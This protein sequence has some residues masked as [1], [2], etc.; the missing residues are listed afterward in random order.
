MFIFLMHL[1]ESLR[2]KALRAPCK[3][4]GEGWKEQESA[5]G[6]FQ[7]DNADF[8]ANPSLFAAWEAVLLAPEMGGGWPGN[9]ARLCVHFMLW[10]AG[11]R[12]TE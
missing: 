2:L 7:L 6:L 11:R 9:W 12:G 3:W 8:R 1:P 5:L 4:E 10:T